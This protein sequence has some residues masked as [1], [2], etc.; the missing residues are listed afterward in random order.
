MMDEA[1]LEP[2][3][4]TAKPPVYKVANSVDI[5]VHDEVEV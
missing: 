3:D 5:L 1:L 2:K 4:A